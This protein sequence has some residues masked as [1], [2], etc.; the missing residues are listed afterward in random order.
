MKEHIKA[1]KI[2]LNDE[3]IA[4]LSNAEFKTLVIR[5]LTQMVNYGCKIEERVKAMKSELKENT[6]G[7]NN[8]RKETRTQ[9]NTQ[10]QKEKINIQPEQNDK[11]RTQKSEESLNKPLGQPEAFQHPNYRG[12][13]RRRTTARN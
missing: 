8:D 13:K 9:S 1:P 2:E 5:M 4:N 10:E 7:I 6:Q 11:T 3:E 12:A